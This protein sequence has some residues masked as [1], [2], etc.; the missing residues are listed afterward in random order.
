MEFNVMLA[1]TPDI[2]GCVYTKAAL[3]KAVKEARDRAMIYNVNPPLLMDKAT[4]QDVFEGISLS[5]IAGVCERIYFDQ[6][7]NCVKADIH[8]AGK[9]GELLKDMINQN[10]SFGVSTTMVEDRIHSFYVD[11]MK[12][13]QKFVSD[14]EDGLEEEF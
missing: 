1:D 4:A 9:N 11:P 13:N 8:F 7:D 5:K 6:D 12:Q 2:N 10:V 14:F 3:Q